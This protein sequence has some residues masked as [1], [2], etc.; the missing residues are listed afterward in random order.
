[1]FQIAKRS[2]NKLAGSGNGIKDYLLECWREINNKG[3]KEAMWVHKS[4][5]FVPNFKKFIFIKILEL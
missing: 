2:P 3:I 5:G 4:N 1:M